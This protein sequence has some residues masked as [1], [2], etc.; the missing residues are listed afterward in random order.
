MIINFIN[1]NI[2][3]VIVDN[4]IQSDEQFQNQKEK[5]VSNDA[6]NQFKIINSGKKI[7]IQTDETYINLPYG[8]RCDLGENRCSL[9]FKELG[10][11]TYNGFNECYIYMPTS[12]PDDKYKKKTPYFTR[13]YMDINATL[14]CIVNGITYLN[15]QRV[16][17]RGYDNKLPTIN[18]FRPGLRLFHGTNSITNARDMYYITLGECTHVWT[19]RTNYDLDCHV[20]K[21]RMVNEGPCGKVNG[22]YLICQNQCCGQD[23]YCSNQSTSCGVGCQKNYGLCM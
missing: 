11:F 5:M 22:E 6:L 10:P 13:I 1:F 17:I 14:K 3:K 16:N 12:G 8:D 21:I 2:G 15:I 4:K 19:H 9:E 23:G 7:I 18:S 20:D